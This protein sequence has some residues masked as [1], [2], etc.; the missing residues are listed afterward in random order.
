M[1]IL[2]LH[3]EIEKEPIETKSQKRKESHVSS[4]ESMDDHEELYQNHKVKELPQA[5]DSDDN[6]DNDVKNILSFLFFFAFL[7]NFNLLI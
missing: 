2:Q 6:G 4:Y 7:Y 3:Y 1:N 5:T